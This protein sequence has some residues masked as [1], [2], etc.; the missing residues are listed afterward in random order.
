MTNKRK[1]DK[2]EMDVKEVLIRMSDLASTWERM[3]RSVALQN[4][5][6]QTDNE[7]QFAE[8]REQ[9]MGE[10]LIGV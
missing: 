4:Q 9:I 3:Q 2:Q 1:K 8:L 7:K 5:K 6:M 10:K